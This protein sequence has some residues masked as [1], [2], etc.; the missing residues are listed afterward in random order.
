MEP[1]KLG[2]EVK[3]TNFWNQW[4][5][6]HCDKKASIETPRK[7]SV[8][9]TSQLPAAGSCVDEIKIDQHFEIIE[10]SDTE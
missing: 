8:I 10:C 5:Q 1:E 2:I 9:V 6:R 4:T 3:F 7:Q